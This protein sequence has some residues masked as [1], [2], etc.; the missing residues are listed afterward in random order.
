MDKVKDGYTSIHTKDEL[1]MFKDRMGGLKGKRSVPRV[2]FEDTPEE[3]T[4]DTNKSGKKV[5]N[6]DNENFRFLSC[7]TRRA[8]VKQQLQVGFSVDQQ[9]NGIK[10]SPN[11]RLA[12]AVRCTRREAT[13]F[14]GIPLLATQ[15][16]LQSVSC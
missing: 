4:T 1:E 6:L 16:I 14:V 3:S 8:P 15:I 7:S 9:R 2:H 13:S 10:R 11:S 12:G 5:C